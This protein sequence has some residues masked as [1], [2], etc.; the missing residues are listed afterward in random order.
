MAVDNRFEQSGVPYRQKKK[1]FSGSGNRVPQRGTKF[2]FVNEQDDKDPNYTSSATKHAWVK[3]RSSRIKKEKQLKALKASV[4]PFPSS[5]SLQISTKSGVSSLNFR[6]HQRSQTNEDDRSKPFMG[7][8]IQAGLFEAVPYLPTNTIHSISFYC[9][10]YRTYASHATFPLS[11]ETMSL[12][13]YKEG[14]DQPALIETLLF[15]S[16][17]NHA[18]SLKSRDA[19]PYLIESTM[20]DALKLRSHVLK[21]LQTLMLDSSRSISEKTIL[22]I[23]HLACIEAN[24]E[25]VKAHILGLQCIINALGGL[26]NLELRT[27][28]AVYCVD[29]MKGLVLDTPPIFKISKKWEKWIKTNSICIAADNRPPSQ[30]KL[31]KR[32]FNSSW[33]P[34]LPEELVSIL[35]GFQ[36]LIPCYE[37]MIQK[38]RRQMPVENDCLLYLIH[39][40]YML[41]YKVMVD[42]LLEVLSISLQAYTLAR[43]WEW[44]G[45]PCFANVGRTFRQKIENSFNYLLM[46]APD[47]L[48]WSLF[49]ACLVSVGFE[50]YDWFFTKLKECADRLHI[51]DLSQALP[52]LEGFFF[53]YRMSEEPA[54]ELM[55]SLFPPKG[56]RTGRA[57]E[58][59][60]YKVG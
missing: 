40:L 53:V 4:I 56:K 45:K 7:Q 6:G 38:E 31:G 59:I 42:P 51:R 34:D 14:M 23:C 11:S 29:A 39:R 24:I 21:S 20:Q 43:I 60:Q 17:A 33:S 10:H 28:S 26:E 54:R 55:N 2:L 30:S 32:F 13:F 15:L 46:E 12:Y 57:L 37:Q 36:L 19:S 47:L 50:L 22:T 18:A 35:K 16:A 25:G 48:F 1:H 9:H 44:R 27:L 49:H 5:Q 58:F 3:S 8:T 41:P 52:V